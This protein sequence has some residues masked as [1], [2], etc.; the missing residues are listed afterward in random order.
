LGYKAFAAGRAEFEN[1]LVWDAGTLAVALPTGPLASLGEEQA[2]FMQ[3]EYQRGLLTTHRQEFGDKDQ[4]TIDLLASL[5]STLSSRGR[6]HAKHGHYPTARE[7]LDA[8]LAM[9]QE[10]GLQREV[11]GKRFDLGW[12]AEREGKLEEAR[13]LFR[14]SAAEFELARDQVNVR[15]ARRRLAIVIAAQAQQ[16]FYQKDYHQAEPLW[17]KCLD[18][19]MELEPNVWYTFATQSL[20]GESLVKQ[21]QAL[22]ASDKPAA[23]RKFAEA[24]PL[25]M[26]GYQG[27]KQREKQAGSDSRQQLSAAAQRLVELYLAW[28]KPDEAARWQKELEALA[29]EPK[30]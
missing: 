23:G 10:G 19:R 5:A 2:L 26:N 14:R 3:E 20:L 30:P 7:L 13:E 27:L 17:R 22:A 15:A 6:L 12:V 11:A 29:G 16:L 18:L 24:E 4:R 8:S 9:Y 28:E 21:G 1:M 25:L